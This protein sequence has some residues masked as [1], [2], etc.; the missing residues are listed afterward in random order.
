MIHFEKNRETG[1]I[2]PINPKDSNL[3]DMDDTN[4]KLVCKSNVKETQ[5]K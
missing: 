4:F 1:N 3:G 5:T 2:L